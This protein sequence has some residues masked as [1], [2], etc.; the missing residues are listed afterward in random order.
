MLLEP[1]HALS[2]GLCAPTLNNLS[3]ALNLW[4]VSALY[5][6]SAPQA[7]LKP[8]FVPFC[9]SFA[10]HFPSLPSLCLGSC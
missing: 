10:P 1:W 2:R 6:S 3:V 8:S 7:P 4:L 9:P 5:Q